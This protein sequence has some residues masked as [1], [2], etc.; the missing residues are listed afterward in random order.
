MLPVTVPW[1]C[2]ASSK[3]TAA[4]AKTPLT[5]SDCSS[6]AAI[7]ESRDVLL[8]APAQVSSA[9]PDCICSR[10]SANPVDVW[11]SGVGAAS[12]ETIDS[13]EAGS[14]W[15]VSAQALCTAAASTAAPGAARA[16]AG[17]SLRCRSSVTL[18]GSRAT[19]MPLTSLGLKYVLV[20]L[21]AEHAAASDVGLRTEVATT[22]AAARRCAS[23]DSGRTGCC[24][25]L[26]RGKDTAAAGSCPALG[27]PPATLDP[28]AHVWAP[29]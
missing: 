27:N 17:V 2:S 25:F 3:E 20:V 8:L 14:E 26:P 7:K 11:L 15:I 4:T 22:G 1:G 18:V 23:A 19:F 16:T 9:C 24:A 21:S 28:A 5:C 6:T 12:C 29:L 13:A 10:A